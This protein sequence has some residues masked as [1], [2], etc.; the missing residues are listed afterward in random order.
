MHNLFMNQLQPEVLLLFVSY[1]ATLLVVLIAYVPGAGENLVRFLAG[2]KQV[3]R[4]DSRSGGG[5]GKLSN[6]LVTAV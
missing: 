5:Q 3:A 2:L 4:F 6:G 1:L